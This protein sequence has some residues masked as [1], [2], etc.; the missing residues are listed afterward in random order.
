MVDA[1]V[2]GCGGHTVITTIIVLVEE[3]TK[4]GV[5][6]DVVEAV[7]LEKKL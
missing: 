6:I 4:G 3:V 5:A 1:G 2:E 7:K